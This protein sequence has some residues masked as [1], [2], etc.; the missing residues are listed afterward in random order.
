[1]LGKLGGLGRKKSKRIALI[2]AEGL[3]VYVLHK[4]QLIHDAK[5]SDE[6]VGYTNFR[7]YLTEQAI[8]PITL[9]V[10]SVAEDFLVESLP[11]VSY[12]DRK[13]FLN[14]KSLQH[15]RSLEYR[16][17]SV[18][19][20]ESG[21]R[22]NDKVL[23]SAL[24]KNQIVEPWIR[25][26][27]QE[28]VPIQGITTPAFALCKVAE[29]YELLSNKDTLLVNWEATGI[30]QTF[31]SNK[32]MMFSR[33]T[34]TGAESSGE[35]V[36]DIMASCKQSKEYLERIGLTKFGEQLDLHIITPQLANEDFHQHLG[37]GSFRKI[38]HHRPSEMIAPEHYHGSDDSKTA[39]L[40][41]LDWG[42]RHGQLANR[43]ASPPVLRFN[44]L[45]QVRRIIYATCIASALVSTGISLPLWLDAAQRNG[46][47]D[48]LIQQILPIQLEYDSLTAEFPETPI[49][50]EAMQLAVSNYQ[51]INNQIRNPI[52]L[53]RAVSAVVARFPSVTLNSVEWELTGTNPD[54]TVTAALLADEAVPSVNL[55]GTVRGGSSIATSQ[56]QLS[57]FLQTLN[58]IEGA[59]ATPISLPVESGPDGEVSTV[60]NDAAVDA[61]FAIRVRQES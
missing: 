54:A 29:H 42:V 14:R 34:P 59:V 11:H 44:D 33:L 45:W 12:Y 28:E 26:L 30:R 60:I 46:R 51:V 41:C 2:D 18:V 49:P 10:D 47:I 24:T 39:T 17:S 15:F 55:V 5:F 20:R 8:S 9:L 52:E 43:Y 16:S 50:S 53:L 48:S 4:G 7:N 27:L 58:R 22:K 57:V 19:G 25:V 13:G 31:V 6:D 32:R 21:G 1:M 61:E 37:E 3:S 38:E 56:R 40:L 35:L 36:S 23:F